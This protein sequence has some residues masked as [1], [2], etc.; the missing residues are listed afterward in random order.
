M[1]IDR[2]KLAA[3]YYFVIVPPGPRSKSWGWEIHRRS[4]PLDDRVFRV[5]FNSSA[6]AKLDGA[7]ALNELLDRMVR[8]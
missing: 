5:N 4:R 2:A 7:R 6:A 8:K 3:D 1:P